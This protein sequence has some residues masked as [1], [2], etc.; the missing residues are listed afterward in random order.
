MERTWSRRNVPPFRTTTWYLQHTTWC[1]FFA[2]PPL[3]YWSSR[4]NQEMPVQLVPALSGQVL[5]THIS[6][7][8]RS[9][10]CHIFPQR[11]SLEPR[12]YGLPSPLRIRGGLSSEVK[13]SPQVSHLG[14]RPSDHLERKLLTLY[15]ASL[16]TAEAWTPLRDDGSCPLQADRWG[17]HCNEST[18]PC[19][20]TYMELLLCPAWL[21]G[22]PKELKEGIKRRI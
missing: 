13:D 21:N 22:E 7:P 4:I 16:S 20:P 9:P 18:L 15:W 12:G 8:V 3:Q 2:S 10:G 11:G 17:R 19:N 14:R 5:F 6:F 1:W